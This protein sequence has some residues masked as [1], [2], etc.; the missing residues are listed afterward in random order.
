M[1]KTVILVT[2]IIAIAV[3]FI[4]FRYSNPV[5]SLKLELKINEDKAIRRNII[6]AG[7]L[8]VDKLKE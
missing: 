2:L 1:K 4:Y 8:S 3:S 6:F 7:F 5:W